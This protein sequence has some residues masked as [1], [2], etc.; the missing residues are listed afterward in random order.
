LRSELADRLK[1]KATKLTGRA[2]ARN[3]RQREGSSFASASL[4]GSDN[5]LAGQNDG[6]RF[7]LDRGGL[8]VAS[9]SHGG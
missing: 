8:F 1:D 4:R 5:I 9:L 6:N 2:K 3:G 7:L